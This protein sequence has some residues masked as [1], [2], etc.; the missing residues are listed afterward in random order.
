MGKYSKEH[1]ETYTKPWQER[2]KE[3]LKR[4]RKSADL[5]KKYGLT[6]E[7]YEAM[8]ASQEGVC[9][10]CKEP[11]TQACYRTGATYN[12]AVDHNHSTDEIRQL[13]CSRCNRTLGMVNDDIKLLEDMIA[14]LNK[15]GV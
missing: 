11:E 9:A 8:H 6:L 12:L 3:R 14:Y 10:I 15:H 7:E 1:Y 13:L 2:N 4:Y 5:K